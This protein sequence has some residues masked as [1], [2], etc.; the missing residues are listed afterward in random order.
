MERDGEPAASMEVEEEIMTCAGSSP[1][2]PDN[3]SPPNSDSFASS[4]RLGLKNSIQTNFGDDYV[5]Q[6]ASW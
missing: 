3:S 1:S 4:R 6:I 5:F 2:V